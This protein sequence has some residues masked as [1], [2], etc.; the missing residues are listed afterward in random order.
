MKSS[1]P[2]WK[3]V[4]LKFLHVLNKSWFY[5]TL[6]FLALIAYLSLPYVI[7]NPEQPQPVVQE[8]EQFDPCILKT[9][10]CQREIAIE[11]IAEVSAY[12]NISRKCVP[13]EICINPDGTKL[14]VGMAACPNEYPFGTMIYVD[15]VGD[16][17]C[18]D[19]RHET[20]FDLFFGYGDTSQK[21]VE[22]FGTSLRKIKILAQY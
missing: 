20:R 15:G 11:I 21:Q 2:I 10:V 14:E 19:R 12:N 17:V 8:E 6:F 7:L 18:M 9:I 16:F 4:Y 22:A 13:E 1:H 5:L 3:V